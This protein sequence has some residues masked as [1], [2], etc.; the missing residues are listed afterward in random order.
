M[1]VT[2]TVTVAGGPYDRTE[3]LRDGTVRPEGMDLVYV[4]LEEPPEVFLRGLAGEFDAF[5]FSC[6]LYFSRRAAG[7]FPF[8][9]L[10]VFPSRMFRHGYVFVR[11]GRASV[12]RCGLSH[13]AATSWG[14]STPSTY[15]TPA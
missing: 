1:G 8:V 15:R 4:P 7:D 13:Q 10:P 6:S 3:A 14:A 5:E 11:E 12:K 9:A 2:L